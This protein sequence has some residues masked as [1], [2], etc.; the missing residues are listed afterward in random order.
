V[1]APPVSNTAGVFDVAPNLADEFRIF[2]FGKRIWSVDLLAI[3]SINCCYI[4]TSIDIILSKI[5]QD[6]DTYDFAVLSQQFRSVLNESLSSTNIY[7]TTAKKQHWHSRVEI[8]DL[9]RNVKDH[10]G[11]NTLPHPMCGMLG[12]A[13]RD[14]R[15]NWI[16]ALEDRR[17]GGHIDESLSRGM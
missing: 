5:Y 13:T 12:N 11:H 2:C 7:C 4:I 9:F 1:E 17:T 14:F 6:D 8:H 3:V 15:G 10:D 16:T